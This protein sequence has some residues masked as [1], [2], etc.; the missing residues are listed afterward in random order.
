VSDD[1][2]LGPRKHNGRFPKRFKLDNPLRALLIRACPPN[3]RNG[4][5][6][7]LHLAK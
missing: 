6:S 7:I 1:D 2:I 4:V 5:K 3:P